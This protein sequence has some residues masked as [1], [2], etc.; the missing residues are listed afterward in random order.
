MWAAS[1]TATTERGVDNCGPRADSRLR[2]E[3][4]SPTAKECHGTNAIES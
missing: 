4:T 3:S 1:A 2:P